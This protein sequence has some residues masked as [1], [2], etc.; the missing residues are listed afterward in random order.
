MDHFHCQITNAALSTSTDYKYHFMP[1]DALMNI[2][3]RGNN[4]SLIFQRGIAEVQGNEGIRMRDE[5]EPVFD[6]ASL[7]TRPIVNKLAFAMREEPSA[8]EKSIGSSS[9]F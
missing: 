4:T 2:G 3:A 9:Y 7:D 8:N 6:C 1:W 5:N